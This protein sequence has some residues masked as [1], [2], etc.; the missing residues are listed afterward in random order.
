MTPKAK[1]E[2]H[3]GSKKSEI[4]APVKATRVAMARRLA[5]NHNQTLVRITSQR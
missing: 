3:A 5:V 1:S 4:K 2:N